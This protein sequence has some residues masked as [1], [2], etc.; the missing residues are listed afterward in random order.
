M[1]NNITNSANGRKEIDK[2]VFAL[3]NVE[4]RSTELVTQLNEP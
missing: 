1:S 3:H 2:K 4:N